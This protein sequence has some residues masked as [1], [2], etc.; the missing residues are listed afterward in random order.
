MTIRIAASAIAPEAAA[1]AKSDA[2]K[3]TRA[4]DT[5]LHTVAQEFESMLLRQ[6]LTAAHMGGSH[7]KED[8][9]SGMAVDALASGV[10]RSGGLGLA[11]QLEDAV[12]RSSVAG[13]A[14]E[15][16]QIRPENES[17]KKP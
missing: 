14:H 5:R 2:D 6:M 16:P 1:I 10:E 9:Y 8:A 15:T 17:S 12:A 4:S 13:V 3:T 11:R 7:G